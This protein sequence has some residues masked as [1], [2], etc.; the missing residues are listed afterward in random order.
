MDRSRSVAVWFHSVPVVR[1]AVEISGSPSSVGDERPP[2]NLWSL[3]AWARPEDLD[4]TAFEKALRRI[5]AGSFLNSGQMYSALICIVVPSTAST[6]LSR[7]SPEPSTGSGSVTRSTRTPA[8]SRSSRRPIARPSAAMS[9]ARSSTGR[10][11]SPAAPR[12]PATSR[13]ATTS[14]PRSS[15]G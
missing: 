4:D 11:W 5:M 7:S 1:R 12:R 6:P 13:P 2:P 9:S 10:S 3:R 14:S 15:P 8:S